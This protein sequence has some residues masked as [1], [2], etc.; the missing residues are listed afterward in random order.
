M[1]MTRSIMLVHT[2]DCWLYLGTLAREDRN[3]PYQCSCLFQEQSKRKILL[4]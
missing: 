3:K 1:F 2:S 4:K